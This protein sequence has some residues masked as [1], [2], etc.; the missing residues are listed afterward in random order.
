MTTESSLGASFDPEYAERAI[1]DLRE[2]LRPFYVDYDVVAQVR[3]ADCEVK[4]VRY[5]TNL[6]SEAPGGVTLVQRLTSANVGATAVG[7]ESIQ[8]QSFFEIKW[9]ESTDYAPFD[10]NNLLINEIDKAIKWERRVPN[11]LHLSRLE[12]AAKLLGKSAP[13]RFLGKLASSLVA[14][15]NS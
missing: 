9:L 5:F 10:A 13:K 11:Y 2:Q 12:Q 7:L 3:K 15:S 6:F 8:G 4:G 14:H 1:T